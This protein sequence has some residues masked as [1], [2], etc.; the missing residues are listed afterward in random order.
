MMIVRGIIIY[1]LE[2]LLSV[3]T[4]QQDRFTLTAWLLFHN[5]TTV[6]EETDKPPAEISALLQAKQAAMEEMQGAL[7][8][9][10]SDLQTC[11]EDAGSDETEETKCKN[12]ASAKLLGVLNTY[13]PRILV[14]ADW[15]VAWMGVEG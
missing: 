2:A 6:P 15:Q 4:P 9:L 1:F 13:L 8:S 14:P 3:E 7:N 10:A 12:K 11:M 5:L